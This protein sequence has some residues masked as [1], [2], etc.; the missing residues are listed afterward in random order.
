MF[1]REAGRSE[2]GFHGRDLTT[3]RIF[4]TGWADDL[5][6]L[7]LQTRPIYRWL[8]AQLRA[9]LWGYVF[10]PDV[11]MCPASPMQCMLQ[12][13]GATEQKTRLGEGRRL[14]LGERVSDLSPLKT[15]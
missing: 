14:R 4:T 3:A 6:L 8:Q 7:Q 12:Y 2:P 13:C 11:F 5:G 9:S 15:C 10:A 1:Q